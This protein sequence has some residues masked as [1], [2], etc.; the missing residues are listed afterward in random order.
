MTAEAGTFSFDEEVPLFLATCRTASLATVGDSGQP[1]T[2]NIQYAQDA[3]MRLHW[4]SSSDAQHSRDLASNPQAAVTVYGHDDQAMR[5]HGVQMRGTVQTIGDPGLWNEVWELYTAK[6]AFVA[7]MPQLRQ[8]VEQQT[9]YRF[10]PTWAR[11]IDNRRGFGWNM[12][13]TL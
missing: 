5:I 9:F 2:A 11:W 7:A 6:F 3:A 8:I 1:H 12:E 10:T 13:K 4:V